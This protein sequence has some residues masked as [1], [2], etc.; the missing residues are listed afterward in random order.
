MLHDPSPELCRDAVDLVL[1]EAQERLAR[2]DR[3]GATAA[4]RKALSGARDR[5]QVDLVARQLKGLGVEVDL[6]AHFGFLR[7]WML[8]GP[9]DNRDG[10]GFNTAFAPEKG[11]DLAR[12]YE[13]KGGAKL[14]WVEYTTTDPYGVVDLNRALGKHPGATAY[15]FTAVHSPTDQVVEVRAGSENAVKIFL[16]GRL[17]FSRE[18]YHHGMR[19]DQ[20]VG[21]GKLRT[22]R[23]E[24]LVKVCQNEQP[25][26]WAQVWSFQLRVCDPAGGKAPLSEPARRPDARAAAGRGK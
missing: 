17:I 9:F 19:M 10:A 5:D 18:E 20:H 15:A 7:T 16:N 23:N 21:R 26:A 2:G 13:G 1:R 22:G 12:T 24:I 14:H 6:A 11:L 3:P 4:S 8:L 25:E